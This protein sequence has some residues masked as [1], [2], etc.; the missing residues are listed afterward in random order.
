MWV[1]PP[2]GEENE[3]GVVWQLKKALYGT[4]QA[5]LLFPE[6]VMQAMVKIGFTLVR[7]AVQTFYHAAWLVP[8]TVHSDDFTAL[9]GTQSL[10]ML[11]WST[12]AI[13][14]AEEDAKDRA[15]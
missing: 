7:V 8:A 1:D 11:A 14:R 10:H 12:G 13:L 3:H 6:Y 2:N 15:S 9:G 5:A 4:W